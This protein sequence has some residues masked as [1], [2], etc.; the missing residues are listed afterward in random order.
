M[1]LEL[2][3]QIL[4][5]IK[6]SKE[7]KKIL[8]ECSK[9]VLECL[10]QNSK[11]IDCEYF[12]GGS[13]GKDTNLSGSSD[14]D[15]FCR[16]DGNYK[17]NEISNM[18]KKILINSK[19]NFKKQ[20]GSRD[21]FS[22]KAKHKTKKINFEIIPVK[23]IKKFSDAKNTTDIS[24]MHVEFLKKISNKNSKINDEIRMAKQFLK[25]KGLYG[26]E[27]YLN[28]FSGHTVDILI[29]HYKSLE[30]LLKNAKNWN[31]QTIVDINKF[32]KDEDEIIKKLNTNKQSKLIVV[33]PIDKNRNAAKALSDEL[34]GYF[35]YL[36]KITQKLQKEDF[37]VVQLKPKEIIKE[38]KKKSKNLNLKSI[39]YV[40]SFNIEE[41]SQDIVGS[42]LKRLNK[43][44]NQLFTELDF[45]IF[46]NDYYIFMDEQKAVFSF[47]FEKFELPN[48]KKILGPKLSMKEGINQFIKGRKN[49]GFDGERFYS[50]EKRKITNIKQVEKMNIKTFDKLLG[51][52]IEFIKKVEILK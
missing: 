3:K 5:E 12:I 38:E 8:E 1:N 24:P 46:K 26:A 37:E 13:Y 10:I 15:I 51:K 36:A 18:L 44:I 45:E 32:Y 42:R 43:K 16:F 2:K 14:I 40:I 52:K 4:K 23:K 28:G 19:L 50:Y 21:Y 25:A 39:I 27:S 7:E 35:I 20:K 49:I 29:S 6:P 11:E 33:D 31:E 30:N 41:N 17:D 34:Y 48:Q 9:K 47:H 22:I